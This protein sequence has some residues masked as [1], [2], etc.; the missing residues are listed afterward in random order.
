MILV[1]R[2]GS[3]LALLGGVVMVA[4]GGAMV[5]TITPALVKDENP[6]HESGS[7]IGLLANSADLGMALAPLAA[8]ALVES[9]PL[10]TVYLLASII[11]AA[12]L[13]LAWAASRR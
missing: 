13:P 10:Q 5:I 6:L 3:P 12:G 1:S 9:L 8:Y 7:I 4:V 2:P 11:L